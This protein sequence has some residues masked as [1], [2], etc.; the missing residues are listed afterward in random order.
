MKHLTRRIIALIMAV[1]TAISVLPQSAYAQDSSYDDRYVVF[2]LEG[3]TL[4]Q[5]FYLSP[6]KMSYEEI[7]SAWDNAGVNIDVDNLTVSQASYA[8]FVKSG[9]KTDPALGIDYTKNDF[10]L[11]CIKDIDKGNINIPSSIKSAY[12]SIHNSEPVLAEKTGADLSEFDY[13]DTSGWMVSVDNEFIDSGA[14]SYVLSDNVDN[15]HT[16]V[17]RWQFS[18]FDYGS[19]LGI[20]NFDESES[21]PAYYTN[22][23]RSVL[24]TLFADNY[25]LI[26]SDKE[27]YNYIMSVMSEPASSDNDINSAISRIN[28][29]LNDGYV[30]VE[31]KMNATSK[32]MSLKD[33]S[34]NDIS[35]GEPQGYIYSLK[36]KPDTYTLTG[37]AADG[38]TVNG[39]IDIVVSK[40][41]SQSFT[42]YTA[43]N[44]Y[45]T[46]S[47]WTEGA[48]YE[49]SH[50]I[51]SSNG[52]VRHTTL[53]MQAQNSNRYSAICLLGDTL[54][55]T[56]TP[57]G[58]KANDYLPNTVSAT[59]T[60]NRSYGYNIASQLKRNVTITVPKGAKITTGTLANSFS[61][62]T[63]NPVSGPVTD[64]ISGTDTYTYIYASGTT[65]YYKVSMEGAVTYWNWVSVKE[66]SSFE[67]TKDD[68]YINDDAHNPDTVIDDMT[69]NK[70]DV[71]DIYMNVNSKG[72]LNLAEND[73][74]RLECYRNWQAI[75]GI[76][77]AKIAEPDF[78]YTVIDEFGNINNDIIELVPNDNSAIADIK[79]TGKGTAIIL[80]TYDA[81]TNAASQNFGG[82]FFSA[83]WPENTGVIVVN[84]G[85]DADIDT[86]M[87]INEGL[88]TSAGK[89]SADRIDAELDVLYYTDE[90][91]GASYTFAPESNASVSVL[92]PY[93]TDGRLSYNGYSTSNVTYNNDG[94]VT[95]NELTHGSN[96]I[97]ITKGVHS[98]YQVVRAKKTAVEYE[99]TDAQGNAISKDELKAGCNVQI[100]FGEEN[101]SGTSCKGIY[102]PAN[103]LAGIY[104]MSGTIN[105]TDLYGNEFKGKS[106]QYLFAGTKSAQTVTVTIP[107]YFT[108]DTYKL[109]GNIYE[110]GFGS[111]YGLH[112][113]LTHEKGKTPQFAALQREGY[114]GKLPDISLP[115]SETD[116]NKVGVT[117]KDAESDEDISDYTLIVKDGTG[118]ISY[119]TDGSFATFDGEAYTYEIYTPGY[120][121]AQGAVSGEALK[122]GILLI[123]LQKAKAGAWDGIS[124]LEPECD[125]AGVYQIKTGA[126]LY[127]FADKVNSGSAGLS[128]ELVS[129]I[130]LAGYRW[131][132]IGTSSKP[133]AGEFNGNGHT[134]SGLYVYDTAYAGLFGSSKGVIQNV[135][136][137]GEI[138]TTK[139]N[140]GGIAGELK[141]GTDERNSTV[142]NCVSMV[143]ISAESSN[144]VGGIAGYCT[145]SDISVSG[146]SN[147]GNI[148][149]QSNAGGIIG[150]YNASALAGAGV[151]DCYNAGI[152]TGADAGMIIG[153]NNECVISNCYNSVDVQDNNSEYIN[154]SPVN[155]IAGITLDNVQKPQHY[156]AVC[157]AYP[158]YE[159]LSG[160]ALCN[161]DNDIISGIPALIDTM[162]NQK[163]VAVEALDYTA[164][165][166]GILQASE[167]GVIV[168]CKVWAVD[169]SDA[170]KKSLSFNN[171]DYVMSDGYISSVNGLGH[172]DDYYM[173]GW[174]LSYNEDDCDNY[175]MDYITLSDNDTLSLR[176]SLTGGDDI[177][178]AYTGL[179]TLKEL[180]IN[181]IKFNMRTQIDYDEYWNPSY[182]YFINDEEADG[183][184]TQDNPFVINVRF[185][186]G[187]KLTDVPVSYSLYADPHF[188]HAEGLSDNMDISGE[189][190]FWVSSNGGRRAYYII[191]PTAAPQPTAIPT[192]I[193]TNTPTAAPDIEPTDTPVDEP[194]AVPTGTPTE[195]PTK[196]P[197]EAPSDIPVAAP[198]A[199]PQNNTS[200]DNMQPVLK[201]GDI[202]KDKKGKALYK[203]TKIKGSKV[204]VK[205]HKALKN[206]KNIKLSKYIYT[207]DGIRCK[208][209]GFT[210]KALKSFKKK[211]TIK[212]PK[213]QYRFYNK[214]L[215]KKKDV[216][217]K[218]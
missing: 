203:V 74:V 154:M 29:L 54:S 99:Y 149:G 92:R 20:D 88:N 180:T 188:A 211:T 115:L 16:N 101:S 37:Y 218:R 118:N 136:V 197:T 174:M 36:L 158:V 146:C 50:T 51:N 84:V 139:S 133:F 5:G 167:S 30:D 58:D 100:T 91:N 131:T 212:V 72:Y 160:I 159:K 182:T 140:A 64:E 43:T 105:V 83:I 168:S 176:Y 177:A 190:G 135:A 151:S 90:E 109:S 80:V 195:E 108:G 41:P 42:V 85:E 95:V 194:T 166:A 217:L 89:L 191:R 55:V 201:K 210:K 153:Y 189:V 44:I 106:N 206:K 21:I 125:A 150:Y 56:V 31:I 38:E 93:Y 214:L 53:G 61:Y 199:V 45:C 66:D 71:A 102:I 79:A 137:Q 2:S 143:N 162:N 196:A 213:A 148:T 107:K 112:R 175:G 169:A 26:Q 67:V 209:K 76:S 156:D 163:E 17:I 138:I 103:K 62:S 18:L 65:Y 10:Y 111:E 75:E 155:D 142:K 110:K 134:I 7:K 178:A 124:S 121:Y 127:W 24:Y 25:Q 119:V 198:T 202:I 9:L 49:I 132:P 52:D 216:Y 157:A 39:T 97:K 185:P 161:T 6:M 117:V 78:H 122:E 152:I 19:D 11:S 94:T 145:A 200:Q 96:I 104:N 60:A 34:G 48:D 165:A 77:N 87:T 33:A 15:D 13:T 22:S 70:Y 215:K 73:S 32:T 86:G 116:F 172:I 3:L 181:N 27:A 186:F 205:Y 114:F 12:K 171:I 120:N 69:A 1:L 193:P 23:D 147:Y 179:P 82:S 208:V 204:I 183:E 8:F 130:E 47:G 81:M 173:S 63:L 46:N 4:G 126:E 170:V 113:E 144:N 59:I 187:T 68:L 128:A 35:V 14:G 207:K 129:D 28:S 40:E 98:V 192:D 184:G 57:L 141:K 123:T 164:K